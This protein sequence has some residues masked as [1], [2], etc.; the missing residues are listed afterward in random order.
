MPKSL[1]EAVTDANGMQLSCITA[2]SPCDDAEIFIADEEGICPRGN[3]K[4]KAYTFKAS[5]S[6]W[7]WSHF[8]KLDNN[9]MFAFCRLCQKEVY[10]SKCYSTG[11]LIRHVKNHHKGVYSQHLK[12]VAD[13]VPRVEVDSKRQ[14]CLESSL[15]PCP[16]FETCLVNWMI[17]TYQ[18]LRCCEDPTFREMCLS[19]NKKS[20]ILSRE[21]LRSLITEE[22]VMT[23]KQITSILKGKHFAFTTDGWTSLANVGYVTCTAHFIDA[24]TWKLH[25]IVLGL[26]EKDGTSKADDIVNYCESQLTSFDLSYPRAVA[27]V[28][29]TEA[30][31]ISAGRLLVSRSLEQG[32]KTKW[33]GCIDHLLQLVTKKAFSDLPQ[34]E[35]TL[36]AC[37]NLVNFFNSS[38]QATK[39][40]LSKQVEGRAVKPIQDV[41]TRWWST[42]SMVDRLLR[43]K[44]YLSLLEN[45]GE[46]QCNLTDSQWLIVADLCALLKPFMI[47]QKLLEGE[48]YVTISLVPYMV[49]KTR[50]ALVEAINRPTSSQYIRSIA[51]AMLVVFNTHFGQGLAGTIATENLQPGERRRPKGINMLAL[52]ASFLDPRMKGG[53]GILEDDRNEI[54]SHIRQHMI[55]IAHEEIAQQPQ[56]HQAQ[57]QAQVEVQQVPR[58]I[59]PL[60]LDDLDIFDELN[61]NYLEEGQV[62]DNNNND[63]ANVVPIANAV[64]AELTLYKQEPSIRLNN[65][66]GTYTCPLTWWK[67]NERKYKLLSKLAARVLCIPAT[68]APSERVFSTAGLTIAKDRAR[69]ASDTANELI[70]L[71]DALPAIRRFHETQRV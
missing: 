52:M 53:V 8:D 12:S 68:S 17:A 11:M 59:R 39:K 61:N 13:A 48:A 24:T 71:H 51:M 23:R 46:L 15:I 56:V 65:D 18:P 14:G 3:K 1:Y 70:F 29:D 34:S 20:P 28:T 38:P 2:D 64:D 43:L 66:D 32:G 4:R 58:Q 21:K 19:L 62:R 63:L 41:P 30:T 26:Y 54:F 31:M 50:K 37:R 42:Y 69:L 33:L 16:K 10:Y 57:E 55:D 44:L 25:S 67:F 7:I 9:K 36:R 27:V 60:P 6:S 47:T 22:Y 40:L 5:E 45:E 35:G 49:Y